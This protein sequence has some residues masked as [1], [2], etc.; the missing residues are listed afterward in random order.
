MAAAQWQCQ[1]ELHSRSVAAGLAAVSRA[2]AASDGG[3]RSW[4]V[5]ATGRQLAAQQAG[6]PQDSM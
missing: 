6:L 3:S 5:G 1:S 2:V 4:T